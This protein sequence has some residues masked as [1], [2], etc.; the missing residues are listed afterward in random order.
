MILRR[1]A[2]SIRSQDWF[3]VI[4]EILIVVVGIFLGLQVD[5]WNQHRKDR[6]DERVFIQRLHNDLLLADELSSRVRER[7]LARHQFVIDANA[8]LFGT[9]GR[10]QLTRD[11]CSTLG[12]ASYYNINVS[13][14]SSLE[15]LMG[16]GRL[17]I[18]SDV[19]LRT[20]LV[21]LQQTRLAL[22]N[23]VNLQTI[24]SDFGNI[25]TLFPEL[26]QIEAFLDPEDGEIRSHHH[27]DLEAM[28]SN[29]AFLNQWSANADGYDAYIKDG[30]KP[31]L[32]KFDEVHRLVDEKL[33]LTHS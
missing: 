27:C 8:V 29:Q 16:T 3:V 28:R 9:A 19:G 30:L 17:G 1:L 20:A 26:I 21:E 18:I 32:D 2:E 14:F 4:I 10:D 11:E 7:R 25:P 6:A 24:S 22:I 12:S 33:G 13:G 23:M 5:D 15:E 31:W